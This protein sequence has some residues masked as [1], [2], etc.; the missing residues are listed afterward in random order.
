MG[1]GMGEAGLPNPP[2]PVHHFLS[3]W[4]PHSPQG[5]SL[6]RGLLPALCQPEPAGPPGVRGEV[7]FLRVLPGRLCGRECRRCGRQPL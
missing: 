5:R 7:A 4:P 2:P 1:G 6:L 3:P